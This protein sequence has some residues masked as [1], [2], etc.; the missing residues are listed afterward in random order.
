M[1]P[2]HAPAMHAANKSQTQARAEDLAWMAAHGE[3]VNGAADRLGINR[4]SLEK[5]CHRNTPELWRQLVANEA[6]DARVRRGA[7]RGWRV[8]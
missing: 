1:P 5:W 3:T 7:I 4:K 2:N 6:T 8:A